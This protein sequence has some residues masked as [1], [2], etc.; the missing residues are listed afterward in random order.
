LFERR[1]S[2]YECN[3]IVAKGGLFIPPFSVLVLGGILLIPLLC[4]FFF[5]PPVISPG[6]LYI[7]CDRPLLFET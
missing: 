5:E 2:L 3:A 1:A 4:P 7:L 6:A